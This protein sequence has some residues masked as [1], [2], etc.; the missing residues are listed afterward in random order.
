MIEELDIPK[1]HDAIEGVPGPSASA[2]LAGHD[3]IARFLAQA[4]HEGRMHHALLF[5]DRRALARQRSPFIWRGICSLSA[6]GTRLPK[7]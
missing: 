3:E 4:Y 5:E 1:T 7:R 6:T 2:Y